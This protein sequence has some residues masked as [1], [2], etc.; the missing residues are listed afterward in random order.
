MPMSA[1]TMSG[2]IGSHA[3]DRLPAVA[4]RGH[5]NVF[6]GKREFNDPLDRDAVVGQQQLL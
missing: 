4:D 2:A 1:R 5:G 6:I 3:I